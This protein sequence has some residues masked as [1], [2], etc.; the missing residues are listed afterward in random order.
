MRD[1]SN[2]GPMCTQMDAML[3]LSVQGDEDC[4]YLN[5][6]VKSINPNDP[7]PVMVWIHGGSFMYGSGDDL[8]Y[9]PDYLLKKDI[10]LVTI[11]YRVG[12]LGVYNIHCSVS[13][14]NEIESSMDFIL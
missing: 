11:N 5:V 14:R 10:V 1:A 12:I 8:M 6:Y 3:T 4:L 2:Y 9:G 13:L 7:L